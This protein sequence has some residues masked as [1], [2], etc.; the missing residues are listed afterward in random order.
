MTSILSTPSHSQPTE[1]DRDI[2]EGY[3]D[4]SKDDRTEF[5]SSS[6]RSPAYRHGWENGRDDRLRKPR[7]YAQQLRDEADEI[8]KREQQL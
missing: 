8:I 1:A 3:L 4:G 7:A 6:N 2:L 5:P